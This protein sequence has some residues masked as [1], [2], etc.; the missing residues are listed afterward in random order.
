MSSIHA[1]LKPVTSRMF[2]PN[3]G[4]TSGGQMTR[5]VSPQERLMNTL[6]QGRVASR[7]R[8]WCRSS[9]AIY[10]TPSIYRVT[11]DGV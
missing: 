1:T 11:S 8:A 3:K 10:K 5:L 2:F 7:A 4:M 6:D 9:S